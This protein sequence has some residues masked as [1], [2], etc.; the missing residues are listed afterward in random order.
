MG[1]KYVN[2]WRCN[3]N[4]EFWKDSEEAWVYCLCLWGREYEAENLQFELLYDETTEKD[5]LNEVSADDD[6]ETC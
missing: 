5:L 4:G 1:S 3:N 2:C 6:D